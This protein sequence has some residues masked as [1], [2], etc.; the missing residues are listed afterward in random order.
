MD[1]LVNTEDID[2]HR[3]H[4]EM[5]VLHSIEFITFMVVHETHVPIKA[6]NHSTFR[7]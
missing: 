7:E 3:R 5:W 6:S 4:I 2:V 1:A